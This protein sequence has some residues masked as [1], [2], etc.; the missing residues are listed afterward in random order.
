MFPV[1][2][3][4]SYPDSLLGC[5]APWFF[6][7][8]F[9]FCSAVHLW[10]V[11]EFCTSGILTVTRN[12]GLHMHKCNVKSWAAELKTV[13]LADLSLLSVCRLF[14]RNWARAVLRGL[15]HDKRDS[16]VLSSWLSQHSCVCDNTNR[17]NKNNWVV[18]TVMAS[19]VQYV[20]YVQWQHGAYCC[21]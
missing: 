9:L 15:S 13:F 11:P 14:T 2:R 19:T 17:G 21:H 3:Y 20:Q 1:K 7:P 18:C 5:E 10:A 6:S 16:G 12:S 8:F 4:H